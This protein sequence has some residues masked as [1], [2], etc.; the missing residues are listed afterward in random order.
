MKSMNSLI[1]FQA[2]LIQAICEG[3]LAQSFEY[4]HLKSDFH[5]NLSVIL[6]FSFLIKSIQFKQ[7][8]QQKVAHF[9]MFDTMRE[10]NAHHFAK[11]TEKS[12]NEQM[13]DIFQHFQ[14]QSLHLFIPSSQTT[15]E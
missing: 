2:I 8:K 9:Q 7:Q 4:H 11:Q 15:N 6:E 13:K 14:C 10:M 1:Q 12:E 5:S 3:S